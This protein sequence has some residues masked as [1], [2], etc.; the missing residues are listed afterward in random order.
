[1]SKPAASAVET[2]SRKGRSSRRSPSFRVFSKISSGSGA[3][4]GAAL[5]FPLP[6]KKTR[7]LERREHPLL[8]DEHDVERL[9]AGGVEQD[10]DL[11]ALVALH[12]ALAPR[13]VRD[14]R[15][16]LERLRAADG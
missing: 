5:R 7:S 4:I 8:P 6:Q 2:T 16:E 11:V 13:L 3:L 12:R 10:D 9:V 15:L 14:A 1:M